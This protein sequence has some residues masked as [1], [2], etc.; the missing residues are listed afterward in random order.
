MGWRFTAEGGSAGFAI[1]GNAPA[2]VERRLAGAE[3]ALKASSIVRWASSVVIRLRN[4]P[5]NE[6]ANQTSRIGLT[7]DDRD[8]SRPRNP[9]VRQRRHQPSVGNVDVQHGKRADPDAKPVFRRL[10]RHEEVRSEEH[11][12]ELQSLMRISYAVFCL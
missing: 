5:V 2:C 9:D 1:F 3:R 7:G 11:T 12:S 8:I 6:T 10:A 4:E